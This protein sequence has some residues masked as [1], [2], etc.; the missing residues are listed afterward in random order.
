MKI[1]TKNS[2]KAFLMEHHRRH[3]HEFLNCDEIAAEVQGGVQISKVDS[4][5]RAFLGNFP[6]FSKESEF[7]L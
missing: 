4:P 5:R 6:I 3:T 7:P 1:T 2:L